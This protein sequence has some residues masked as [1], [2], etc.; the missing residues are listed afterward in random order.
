MKNQSSTHHGGIKMYKPTV[1][2]KDYVRIAQTVMDQA[3]DG[4]LKNMSDTFKT[5]NLIALSAHI[6]YDLK[7]K[8]QS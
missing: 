6:L 7:E 1:Q 2:Q 8:Q 4:S 3:M 5:E